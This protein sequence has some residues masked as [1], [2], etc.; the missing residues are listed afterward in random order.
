M[1]SAP[2]RSDNFRTV[3]FFHRSGRLLSA[4]FVRHRL[5]IAKDKTVKY[6]CYNQKKRA[7]ENSKNILETIRTPTVK[8]VPP[9]PSGRCLF[10][11]L[12][13]FS[14][15]GRTNRLQFCRICRYTYPTITI[16]C[17]HS[18]KKQLERQNRLNK[19][20]S[21]YFVLLLAIICV[22]SYSIYK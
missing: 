1:I 11:V 7:A 17:R 3:T 12:L 19:N 14:C 9:H 10:V 8:R 15:A 16:V 21:P 22:N 18:T 13:F 2:S 5:S 20:I 6:S 4:G